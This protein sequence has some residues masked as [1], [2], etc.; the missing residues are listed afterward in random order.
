MS[1]RWPIA[2]MVCGSGATRWRKPSGPIILPASLQ[3]GWGGQF[4]AQ[5]Q[6]L[7]NALNRFEL[8]GGTSYGLG[9]DLHCVPH[10]NAWCHFF[11]TEA[12][13]LRDGLPGG[14]FQRAGGYYLT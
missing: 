10:A 12:A 5:A 14:A 7:H 3:P 9:E 2:T 1:G 8:D 6:E 11:R 13:M 4:A